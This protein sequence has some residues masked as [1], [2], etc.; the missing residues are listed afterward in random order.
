MSKILFVS[1]AD[2]YSYN[3]ASRPYSIILT[4]AGI[5]SNYRVHMWSTVLITLQGFS[6]LAS[7][8]HAYEV[9]SISTRISHQKYQ[10]ANAYGCHGYA[11]DTTSG[12]SSD[13]HPPFA[14]S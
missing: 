1:S 3:Q 4:F 12:Q 6:W 11:D 5:Y 8:I 7:R 14:G 10:I 9:S 2:R 13:Q